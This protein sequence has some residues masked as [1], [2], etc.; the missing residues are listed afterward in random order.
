MQILRPARWRRPW[1]AGP[2]RPPSSVQLSANANT[3]A[4]TARAATLVVGA[5]TLTAQRDEART[6]FERARV[7]LAVFD[8]RGRPRRTLLDGDAPGA[9]GVA[10]VGEE[11]LRLAA[12]A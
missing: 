5:V 3:A 4:W 1:I 7:K 2:H 11:Q 9:A 10:T 12:R 6:G 8:A